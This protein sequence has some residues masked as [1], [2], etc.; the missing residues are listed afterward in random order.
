MKLHEYQAR[1][2]LTS[3][4]IP[5]PAGGVAAIPEEAESIAETLGG[6]VVLKAQIQVAGRGK[7]GGV[8]IAGGTGDAR[9]MSEDM[10]G[11]E[12]KGLTVRKLLVVEVLDIAKEYYL[13]AVMDRQNKVITM[14]AS[15][16]GGVEIEE[17]ARVSPEKIAREPVDPFAGLWN[18]QARELGFKIGLDADLTKGFARIASG[19]YRALVDNDATLV[20]INPLVLTHEGKWIA[21]DAKVL[22]DDNSLSRR[23]LLEKMRDIDQ[24]DPFERRAR[25]A[26]ITYVHLDGNIGCIVNGAGLAMATMDVIKLYGGEPANFLDIGGGAKS[27]VV[28]A[29]L[30]TVLSD[31]NVKVI[32]V[33]I[34]GGITRCDDV[35]RGI[36]SAVQQVESRAPMVI[37]LVGTNESEGR[38]ILREAGFSVS[39]K[40]DE[41]AAEAVRLAVQ[42]Q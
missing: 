26:G 19:L 31:P 22:I 9:R 41:A 7:A 32:L 36:V 2:I 8:R 40:M 17:V 21:G 33:N 23:P 1:E 37:R 5:V 14:M 10:L 38:E 13:S 30:E 15:A 42:V 16:E 28:A 25:L 20:E 24:E 18:Y 6:R 27:E 34:F 12:I 39:S 3:Y 4:E 11:M 35:A 29:A